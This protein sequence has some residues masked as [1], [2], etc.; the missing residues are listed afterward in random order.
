MAKK[1]KA[2]ENGLLEKYSD[3][4]TDASYV[5]S[6]RKTIIPTTPKID[7]ILDGGIPEGSF[8]TLT[9]GPGLGKS[10]L[11]LKIASEAQKIE[12]D[13]GQRIVF[14][15]DVEG[16][17]KE[18]D[19]YKTSYLDLDPDKFKLIQS[20]PGK[21]LN[22]EDFLNINTEFINGFPGCVFIIDSFSALCS[23][24]RYKHEGNTRI[25]D[26]VPLLLSHFC[27]TIAQV[28]PINKC[29]VIGITHQIANQGTGLRKWV[30]ASG[31]KIKYQA[32][33]KLK[34]QYFTSWLSGEDVVGQQIF[35]ECEKSA[36]G[37]P[38][39]K[40]DSWLRYGYGFDEIKEIMDLAAGCNILKGAS[41]S[42]PKL[43]LPPEFEHLKNK[44]DDDEPILMAH[45]NEKMRQLLLDNPELFKAVKKQVMSKFLG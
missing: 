35:W 3:I 20:K 9:G 22:G 26:N 34:G 14:Y 4:I 31:E 15:S 36:L 42:W 8:V 39:R 33:V 18:R 21:I 32:D 27:K 40:M 29:I 43:I 25:R 5:K 2:L 28:I 7:L 38:G 41:T 30:E 45:G 6:T 37:G 16:R 1:A 17:I 24:E 12:S 19:L 23:D 10:S 11:A 44:S 13:W